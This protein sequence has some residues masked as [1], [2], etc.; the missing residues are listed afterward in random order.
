M[1]LKRRAQKSLRT[2]LVIWFVM[3]S[4]VPLAFVTGYS[5]IRYEKAIDRELNQRLEGNGRE[6]A[7]IFNDIKNSMAG[8]RDHLLSDPPFI[9]HLSTGDVPS[10]TEVT[11][12]ALK[13]DLSTG[14]NLFDRT[15]KMLLSLIKDKESNIQILD[16]KSDTAIYLAPDNLNKIKN[17]SEYTAIEYNNDNTLTLILFSRVNNSA[18][19]TVGFLEQNVVITNQ[20]L[21][22]LKKRMRLEFILMKKNGTVV[23][24]TH[25]D[26]LEYPKDY[27]ISR[28][29]DITSDFFELTLRGNPYGFV[30]FPMRWGD[31]EFYMA[32]GASK[33][34]ARAA[35]KNVNYAFYGVVGGVVLLLIL[36]IFFLT[37]NLLKPLDDLVQATQYI[38]LGENVAEIP[39][40]SDTEIGLLT[41][42]FND[43]SRSILRARSDLKAKISELEKANKELKD[44]QT[45]LIQSSKMSSLGQLVAGVAHE[46]NNPIS[47]IYSNMIHLRE[48]SEKLLKLA[49]VAEQNPENILATK[50]E[51][52]IEFIKTDLPKLMSSCEEGARRTRDIV[53][54]LRNFSRLEEGQLRAVDINSMIDDTITLL[55]GEIKNRIQMHKKYSELPKVHC[56][57]TQISQVFMNILSNAIQSIPNS[58][59]IWI[60]SKKMKLKDGRDGV[61]ISIQDNGK[62]MT[63]DVQ[64]K[65]FDPFFSTKPVGQGTGLGLSISYGIIQNHGGD[66]FVKSQ[67]DV[68]TEFTVTIPTVQPRSV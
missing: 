64:E 9:F 56:Y 16:Q 57:S 44:T 19:K 5:V 54:G 66:I 51:L 68:G 11:E 31:N 50:R 26:F 8:R 53:L 17:L 7:V 30:L 35:L 25:N 43:M 60:T 14:M 39:I 38:Q 15:G 59:Q 36:I 2:T 41:E 13:S 1:A 45:R 47:F 23:G 24:S 46:L 37:K 55:S 29:S 67:K 10:L 12:F 40:K 34:E 58:G 27:F 63:P 21:D 65:I 49:E 18:G 32:M 6:V 61:S 62:G 52:E 22:S 4:V 28:I 42:S 20:F 48:Y 3:M 33:G